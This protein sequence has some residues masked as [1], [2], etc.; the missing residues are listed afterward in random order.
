M[1]YSLIIGSGK[2]YYTVLNR[3]GIIRLCNGDVN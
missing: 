2:A 1:E 3:D